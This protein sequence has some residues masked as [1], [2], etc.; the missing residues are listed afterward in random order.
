MASLLSFH[1]AKT[2]GYVPLACSAWSCSVVLVDDQHCSL[3]ATTSVTERKIDGGSTVRVLHR[4]IHWWR[5]GQ[6]RWIVRPS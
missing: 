1:W 4:F 3:T 5:I 6:F 2:F